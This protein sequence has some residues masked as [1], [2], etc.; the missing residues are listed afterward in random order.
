MSTSQNDIPEIDL[1]TGDGES[2]YILVKYNDRI[3][4]R[5]AEGKDDYHN[6]IFKKLEGQIGSGKAEPIGGGKMNVDSKNKK[7]DVHGKSDSYG[8]ADHNQ[9]VSILKKKY[10]D[11]TI[12]VSKD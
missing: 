5:K 12:Q 1:G 3:L 6:D 9:T 11:W 8:P 2:K 4:V 10:P 7:I